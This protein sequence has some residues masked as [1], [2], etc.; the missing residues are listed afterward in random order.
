MEQV[1]GYPAIARRPTAVLALAMAVHRKAGDIDPDVHMHYV[2]LW[3]GLYSLLCQLA[4]ESAA[5]SDPRIVNSAGGS[6]EQGLLE[7]LSDQVYTLCGVL[8][9]HD[10]YADPLERMA[11]QFGARHAGERARPTPLLAG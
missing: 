3:Q 2:S 7:Q 9:R 1:L 4:N 6:L 5:R 10:E 8:M 11:R